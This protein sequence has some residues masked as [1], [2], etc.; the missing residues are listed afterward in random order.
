M[1]IPQEAGLRE[2]SPWYNQNTIPRHL[3]V[4]FTLPADTW[5]KVVVESGE[6]EVSINDGATVLVTPESPVVVPPKTQVQLLPPVVEVRFH[7]HYF[8]T[9][10][11][12]DADSLAAAITRG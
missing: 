9:H 10:R 5:G 4:P 7:I 6:L 12:S 11:I 1:E 2:I 8:H 3:R